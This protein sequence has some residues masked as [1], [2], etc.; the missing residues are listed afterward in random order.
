M[1][2]VFQKRGWEDVEV[3]VD[4]CPR[5]GEF[6]SVR[7]KG[8]QDPMR[9]VVAKVDWVLQSKLQSEAIISIA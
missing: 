8:G 6:V 7:E 1:R 2:I 4:H 5:V 3:E 9:G